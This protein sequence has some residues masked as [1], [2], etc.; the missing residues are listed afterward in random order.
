MGTM[1]DWSPP[2]KG[3]DKLIES[4]WNVIAEQCDKSPD[5]EGAYCGKDPVSK[6]DKF[7]RHAA[8]RAARGLRPQLADACDAYN[9]TEGYRGHGMEY[10]SPL[11][12]YGDLLHEPSEKRPTPHTCGNS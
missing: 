10:R 7:R 12:V 5:F 2:G 1:V 4:F 3:R 9:R 11:Q 6:P 8:C